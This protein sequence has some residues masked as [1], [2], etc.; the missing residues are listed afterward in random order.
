MWLIWLSLLATI[1]SKSV[2]LLQ[3]V[4]KYIDRMQGG[5]ERRALEKELK[6][7]RELRV[8]MNSTF[9]YDK[10]HMLTTIDI[11]ITQMATMTLTL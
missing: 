11:I 10:Q 7:I 4:K 2:K 8:Y 9:Y 6:S 3:D 1:N 5:R